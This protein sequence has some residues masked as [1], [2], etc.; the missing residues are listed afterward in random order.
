MEQTPLVDLLLLFVMAAGGHTS[1]SRME[2]RTSPHF[3][4]LS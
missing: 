4:R 1:L 3:S 2:A